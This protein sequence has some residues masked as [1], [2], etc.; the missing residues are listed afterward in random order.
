MM[1]CLAVPLKVRHSV[2]SF[3]FFIDPSVGT[4]QKADRKT[5]MVSARLD[6]NS[7]Q[8]ACDEFFKRR[9]GWQ[10]ECVEAQMSCDFVCAFLQSNRCDNDSAFCSSILNAK[11]QTSH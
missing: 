7:V 11:S 6:Q 5:Y 3:L 2:H 4:T 10:V 1:R 8:T 9:F